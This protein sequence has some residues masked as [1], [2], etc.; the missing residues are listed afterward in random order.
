MH[1]KYDL[2]G[3]RFGKL[4]VLQNSGNKDGR[5]LWL[6]QCD[7]GKQ[8]IVMGRYLIK[9]RTK[10]CGCY[11]KGFGTLWNVKHGQSGSTEYN[12]W[13]GMIERCTNPK[14]IGFNNYGG[15]G[16]KVCERWLNSF[17][18]FLQDMGPKPTPKHSLERIDNN[19]DYEPG[20]CKWEIRIKQNRNQRRRKDNTSGFRGVN[21]NKKMLKWQVYI[22]V[23]KHQIHLGYFDDLDTAIETRKQ[24]E[25]RYWG[26]AS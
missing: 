7:C 26:E 20:N 22:C 1:Q 3:K 2:I 4:V 17:E 25:K 14:N 18:A 11:R 6:C 13:R 21:W 16:I 8:T 19:G 9:G 24:A 12:S 10:S 15:R 23:N 5:S